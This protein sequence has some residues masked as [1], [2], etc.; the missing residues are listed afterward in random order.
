MTGECRLDGDLRRF[1][2]ADL[3]DHDDVGVL[4]QER[5][6]RTREVQ[7]DPIAHLNL[8]NAWQVELDRVLR[9]GDVLGR[10]VELRQRRV[11]RGGLT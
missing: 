10:L 1:E 2:I 11:E 5:T 6:Q 4:A 9:G 3:T 7:A 8:V